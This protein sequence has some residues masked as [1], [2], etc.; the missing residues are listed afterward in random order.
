[1]KID[2]VL[3]SC[4]INEKYIEYFPIIHNLWKN[5]FNLE[6][7]LILISDEIPDNL[8]EIADNIILFPPID[9]IH[10][11]YISQVI[12]ILYPAL[13]NNK[14]ILITDCDIIPISK[15]YFINNVGR[16]TDDKFISYRDAYLKQKMIAI[17][18]NLANSATWASIFNIKSEEDIRARLIEWYNPE[19]NGIKNCEGW[20]TDQKKLYEYVFNWTEKNDRFIQLRDNDLLFNRLDK[21]DRQYI[22]DNYKLILEKIRDKE[23]TDFHIYKNHH[24]SPMIL[25]EIINEIILLNYDSNKRILFVENISIKNDNDMSTLYPMK[26]DKIIDNI[27]FNYLDIG[28]SYKEEEIKE[29]LDNSSVILFGSR[30]IHLYKRYNKAV[31]GEIYIR[32][33]FILYHAMKKDKYILL[34]D[35]HQRTYNDLH[36]L[37][38]YLNENRINIIYT[39]YR[40]FEAK[41]IN[42]RTPNCKK[43]WVPHHIN[44]S[45]FRFKNKPKIY[46]IL[47]FG[48]VEPRHY[49]FRHRLFE[50]ILNNPMLSCLTIKHIKKPEEFDPDICEDGLA[51]IISS[52]RITVSTESKYGYLVAKYF[53]IASCKS[54]IAGN[55]P[56]DGVEIFRDNYLHLNNEMRDDEIIEKLLDCLNNYGEY[57]E[58]IEFISDKINKEYNLDKYIER[59]LEILVN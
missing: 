23:Y 2:F 41:I 28:G 33:R 44:T 1:M 9:N 22:I 31:R 11:A 54:L 51:D 47:L 5:S 36:E 24:E 20:Y 13:F 32:N 39:F 27:N 16:Y 6:I 37:A 4:N 29:K 53:E 15:R 58:K 7:K 19:Y 48:S 42:I 40:C 46:D 50:L 12:R 26:C 35:I 43:F 10:S 38:E 18:Y 59:L 45:I 21:R 8:L 17:C 25:K 55:M 3:T 52:S 49:P 30:S 34:Q 57:K 14:N 56:K